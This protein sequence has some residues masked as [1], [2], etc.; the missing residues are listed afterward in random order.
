M[1][2]ACKSRDMPCSTPVEAGYFVSD[3][4]VAYFFAFQADDN[5]VAT[6]C[7]WRYDGQ[8]GTTFSFHNIKD[9]THG[10]YLI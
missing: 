3:S 2:Q 9:G 8:Q 7:G 10:S 5:I 1:Y 4:G 6:A